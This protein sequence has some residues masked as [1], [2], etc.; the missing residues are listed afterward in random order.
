[1]LILPF[2]AAAVALVGRFDGNGWLERNF[3]GARLF[4]MPGPYEATATAAPTIASL[5]AGL[6]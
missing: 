2:K 4:V 3:A 6:P 1:V 5:G